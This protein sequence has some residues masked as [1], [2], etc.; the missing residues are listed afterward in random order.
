[1]KLPV[2]GIADAFKSPFSKRF[3]AKNGAG[4]LCAILDDAGRNV[5]P[6]GAAGEDAVLYV[7]PDQWGTWR[8]GEFKGR[9]IKV[10]V[11]CGDD[12]QAI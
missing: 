1:M 2:I 5:A 11:S 10:L 9:G 8:R 3:P 12:L 4:F 7:M 6:A